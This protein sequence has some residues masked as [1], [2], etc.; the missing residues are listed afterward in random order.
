[1]LAQGEYCAATNPYAINSKGPIFFGTKFIV[2]DFFN[3]CFERGSGDYTSSG[4][5]SAAALCF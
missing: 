4:R 3:E 2:L 5:L 1:M